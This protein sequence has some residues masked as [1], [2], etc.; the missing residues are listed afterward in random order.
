MAGHYLTLDVAVEFGKGVGEACA[1]G[2]I[3]RQCEFIDC[4]VSFG[5]GAAARKD[6]AIAEARDGGI[7]AI[8]CDVIQHLNAFHRVRGKDSA[9][10]VVPMSLLCELV[11][12]HGNISQ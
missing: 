6:V 3:E 8:D 10:Q 2:M 7:H 11:I 12:H 4:L 1:H 5:D 9:F